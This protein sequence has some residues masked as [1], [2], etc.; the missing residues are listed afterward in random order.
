MGMTQTARI[1]SSNRARAV[2]SA[3]RSS[4]FASVLIACLTLVGK[5]DAQTRTVT[6][7]PQNASVTTSKTIQFSARVSFSPSSVTWEVNGVRGGNSTIGTISSSGRYTAP[8]AVPIVNP[9]TVTARSTSRPSIIGSSSLKVVSAVP[10]LTSVSP[11]P[12]PI[13]S[14]TGTLT[15][16]G[17]ASNAEVLI[18]GVRATSTFVSATRLTVTGTAANAGTLTFSVRQGG[19]NPVTSN[20][21]SVSVVAPTIAVAVTPT[22]ASVAL[23]ATQA[24]SAAVSG[25]TNTAV[26]WSVNGV[27][28][29]SM[30]TGTITATGVYTAPTTLPTPNTVTVRAASAANTASGASATVTLTQSTQT[31]GSVLTAA[32]FL[33]Q[34][35]FGPTP[36]T[37]T[38]VQ[39]I[40]LNAYLD[41]QLNMAPTALPAMTNSQ[42]SDLRQWMLNTYSTAPDQLRQRV[43][44]ALSQIV[45]TSGN[46]LVTP[47]EILPWLRILNDRAF[48]NYRDLLREVT[49]SPSMGKYLDLA[50]SVKPT[51]AGGANENY[52]REL[53]QLFTIGLVRLNQDGSVMTGSDGLPLSTYTQDTVRQVALALTGWTYATAPG[54]TP[55]TNNWEYFGAPMETRQIVHDTSAK[56]F[57]GC[58]L[59]AGQT[60]EQ[61]LDATLDCL[62][63]HPN[64]PPFMATRLIRSLVTSNPSPQYIKRVADVFAGSQSGVRGDLRATV[65]AILTDPDARVDAP[66]ANQGRLKEPILQTVGFLRALNGSFG[67]VNL[68]A[69]VFERFGQAIL[70]PPSVFSWYSPLFKV[71]QGALFGPEFQIYGPNE[72]VLR[73]NFIYDLLSYANNGA[74]SIDL[75]PFQSYGNDMPALVDAVDRVLT[76][77]RMPAAMKQSLVV[78]ATPGADARTRIA[79]VVYLT[80]LSGQY[81][82]QY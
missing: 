78:A 70:T 22:S 32:R 74:G 21:I 46:K 66:A 59:P 26:T 48:G 33:E 44:Y 52:P 45:V 19:T 30:A 51:M 3:L 13:G 64:M 29:G 4:A 65:R 77:G 18:D 60:V 1:P 41:E 8:V 43:A 79:T 27:T 42:V 47:A 53:M 10:T 72:A 11:S 62:M 15:G 58:T 80:A 6:V 2:S 49:L 39:Q 12:I 20:V 31:G 63:A 55:K 23:G 82:V 24:F 68:D 37:L 75:T 54:A 14:F 57:L 56:S 35:S 69:W 67:T 25:T 36:A 28:G 17:F 5:A 76:Y 9:V 50:N 34:S 16:S 81:A 61:D 71:S 73:G 40:G 38:R 7:S